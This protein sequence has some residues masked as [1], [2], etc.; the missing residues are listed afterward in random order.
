MPVGIYET[1][2]TPYVENKIATVDLKR[3]YDTLPESGDMTDQ[4]PRSLRRL[5]A[6]LEGEFKTGVELHQLEDPRE[7]K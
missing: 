2:P 3:L 1:D 4:D 5:K 6:F 7:D